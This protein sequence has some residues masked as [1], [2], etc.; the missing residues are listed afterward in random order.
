[1]RGF[2]M[3]SR[4]FCGRVFIFLISSLIILF[5]L[6][7]V[8]YGATITGKITDR[9]DGM[10][11]MNASVRLL[12][13]DISLKTK[14][15]AADQNGVYELKNVPAGEYMVLV[16]S[17]GFAS[18]TRTAVLAEEKG[19]ETLNFSLAPTTINFEAVSVSASRRPE[20]IVEAPASVS[21]VPTESIESRTTLTPTEHIKSLPAVDVATTG[22]NQSNA[23]VRGFNNIFSGS[24]LVLSDNRIAR[25]PSLRFNAYSFIPTI[26]EDIEKIEV[27]SGPGSALYGPNAASGVMHIITKSPFASRGT[28]ISIGGGE[29][30]LFLSSLRHAGT[31]NSDI[32]YKVTGQ[33]Y[34]GRDWKKYEDS[35]PDT[36]QKFLPT[37]DGPVPVGD[38]IPNHRDFD[39]EKLA[40]EARVDF[41]I[42]N[43]M[44]LVIN[45]G[46]SR[47]RS[48][49]LTGLGAAQAVNWIYSFAQTRFRYKDLFVQ[50]FVN[51]SDAGD[52]YLL[53]TGQL[54]VDKSQL[55]VGQ[56]QHQY[57]PIDELAFTYGFDAL[58]TRPNTESTINGTNEEDDDIN[59][60][61]AY[62]QTEYKLNPY[63]KLVGAARVDDNSKLED[64]I[65]SPRAAVVY[66]PV[67]N[68][69]FR[70]T[71]NR[72][73]ST[74][75]NNSF[76]LDILQS[77]DIGSL[78]ASFESSLGFRP[79]LDI[80]VQGV[81]ETGFH[82]RFNE[83]G[84][85]F[86]SAFAPAAG[87]STSDFIDYNDPVFTNVMWGL[88]RG[89]VI[90][91]F[92]NQLAA[93]GMSEVM[94]NALSSSMSNVT[95]DQMMG[96]T[97]R[98]MTINPDIGIPGP[99][100][101]DDIADIDRLQPTITQTFELGYN[102][103]A[104]KSFK[105]RLDAYHTKKNNFIGPLSVET[106]NVYLDPATLSTT[107][108]PLIDAALDAN[109][110][111]AAQLEAVFGVSGDDL[112]DT[113]TTLFTSGTAQIPFGTVS[114]AEAIDP[115]AVLV[116]YRNFGDISFYGADVA[117]DYHLNQY[118]NFGGN[119]SYVSKNFFAQSEEQIHDINLN[120]PRHKAGFYIHFH[121]PKIGFN[122]NIR[123]RFV[124]A[125][126]M[127]SPFYGN[128]V[129]SY[130]LVDTY[131]GVNFIYGSYLSLT[132]QNL[133]D[134]RHAEFV[135]APEIGRLAI[136]RLTYS[137]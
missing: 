54:I 9:T 30:D 117:F 70:L 86:R 25:V 51:T 7:T 95:P 20:K 66:E 106:P 18:E 113:L 49:E 63:L 104:G 37:T 67:N 62:L 12:S 73:Y 111:D 3:D 1:M 60:Y 38:S 75:D 43:D 68:H 101:P 97:N 48:I 50:G 88:G 11:L 61:G 56:I 22:L 83:N 15:T 127:D 16:S 26:N 65:F 136:L 122:A 29:R 126:D 135:G 19:T 121:Y 46:A 79:E 90:S 94:I 85:Q 125:F 59:E 52:T 2:I 93:Q 55:W 40:G 34:R 27:V 102:G 4:Q 74:P 64:M 21:V 108:W 109:P 35:E 124:D 98:L 78:G 77:N 28:T 72:A 33:Y 120:A 123:F 8:S 23:V 110:I 32:G 6:A 82:W 81:P 17:V 42:D 45:G 130:R 14:G 107:L 5:S 118:W 115:T 100:S 103:F 129:E 58:L 24:L 133:L 80:R 116:T 10:A 137:L 47:A 69:H 44:S 99:S 105:F 119:Y 84:P 96:L 39:I 41:L 53:N 114:P 71:Y 31:I 112:T 134:N 36:I 132:V 76:Y 128:S 87:L 91:A 13:D 57:R 92:E 89:A 131:L